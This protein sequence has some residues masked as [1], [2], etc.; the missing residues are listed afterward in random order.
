MAY[1]DEYKTLLKSF[2]QNEYQ[3]DIPELD[4]QIFNLSFNSTGYFSLPGIEERL[5]K[6]EITKNAIRN[7]SS[8]CYNNPLLNAVFDAPDAMVPENK[9]F[10]YIFLRNSAT[11][12]SNRVILLFHGLNE[13]SWA[14]YLVWGT[15]LLRKTGKSVILFPITFHMN[16]C[17]ESWSNRRLM[18]E[19]SIER[20]AIFPDLAESSFA[21]AAI[22]TRLSTR[23]QRFFY[24]GFQT[25]Y[26]LMKLLEGI[27]NGS[28]P[29][30]ESNAHID[31][32]SYSIGAFL[33]EILFFTG[34]NGFLNNSRL[35]M[36]CGGTTTDRFQPVVKTI[37]D[38]AAYKKFNDFYAR[39]F[40][41]EVE[42]NSLM[43]EFYRKPLPEAKA[44]RCL[45]S[46]EL[47]RDFRE[48]KLLELSDRI[49]A[50][51]LKQDKVIPAE[52]VCRTLKGESG[53]I[54]INVEILDYPYRYTHETPF[55]IIENISKSVDMYFDLTF[56]KISEFFC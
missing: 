49:Y 55:P 30:I 43:R 53:N 1:T 34:S 54:P 48:Q 15:T 37:M 17:P 11:K 21:N 42:S 31:V 10:K 16:R 35:C 44:F 32:F 45:L 18:N 5:I 40:D 7:G 13:K 56:S 39:N 47:M 51:P 36:F 25:Y 8:F 2:N 27:R 46:S 4:L 14:K 33:S 29:F 9:D 12:K 50:I 19:V 28:D 26:D 52:A 3:I 41:N 6:E 20:K 23:P 24:S 22:S 38:S